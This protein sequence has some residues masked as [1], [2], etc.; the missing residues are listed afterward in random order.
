MTVRILNTNTIR[1]TTM[2]VY[3]DALSLSY[4]VGNC[5]SV[6]SLHFFEMLMCNPN[7]SSNGMPFRFTFGLL[8]TP[9]L[10]KT[11][12]RDISFR[13]YTVAWMAAVIVLAIVSVNLPFAQTYPVYS[14][15]ALLLYMSIEQDRADV[16]NH[17]LREH[18]RTIESAFLPNDEEGHADLEAA[19]TRDPSQV[20]TGEQSRCIS[21][22][23]IFDIQSGRVE[24]I[25]NK[26]R[27]LDN[28][29]S[30][31]IKYSNISDIAC[32]YNETVSSVVPELKRQDTQ[33]PLHDQ[34]SAIDQSHCNY[35]IDLLNDVPVT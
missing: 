32:V 18:F 10:T 30:Y 26:W 22:P 16:E 28:F 7:H 4:L 33:L 23:P 20:Q 25:E 12:L 19:V 1:I 15:V 14:M 35:W 29:K 31:D 24:D 21:T 34:R 13:A 5:T 9:I 6:H 11:A 8:L 17:L 3:G 27:L 2:F